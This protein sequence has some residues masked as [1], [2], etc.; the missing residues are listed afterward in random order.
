MVHLKSHSSDGKILRK[1]VFQIHKPSLVNSS[2]ETSST[3]SL[4]ETLLTNCK[5]IDKCGAI[6]NCV[7]V[8]SS[9]GNNYYDLFHSLNNLYSYASLSS[10]NGYPNPSNLIAVISQILFETDTSAV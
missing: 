7:D 10:T 1:N 3:P 6:K 4:N 9:D 8:S 5:E 2:I